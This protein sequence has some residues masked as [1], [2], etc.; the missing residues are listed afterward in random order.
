ETYIKR[1]V[2]LEEVSN[3]HAGV[4][5]TYAMQAG[6]ELHVMVQPE[7]ISDAEAT[8]LAHDIA[9]E[10]EDGMEYPGQVRV[11]VIRESRAVDVAK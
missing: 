3:A 8:V 4:E 5:R 7:K 2:K 6:R 9:H 1:L 11:V 10:L